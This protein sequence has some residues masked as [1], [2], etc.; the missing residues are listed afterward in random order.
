MLRPDLPA[1]E[2]FVAAFER[3]TGIRVDAAPYC[4]GASAAM[5][6]ELAALVRGGRKR[7]TAAILADYANAGEPLPEVGQHAAVHD[8]A[9]R[10]VCIVRTEEVTVGPLESVLDPA[11]AWDEG[12]GDRT[13]ENWLAGHT[14]YW[15]RTHAE[16][17][18]AVP[19]VLQRFRVVWPQVDRTLW[20]AERNGVRV[21]RAWAPDRQWLAETMR[22][23]WDGCVVSR[24]ALQDPARLPAL[25]AVDHDSARLG[26][27]TFR[28]RPGG[29]AEVVTVDALESGQGVGRLLLEAVTAVARCER[30][31]RLWL[32]TTNDN[33]V[34]LRAYQRAGWDLV[35]VHRDAVRYAR[36]LKPSIPSH[37]LDGIPITHELELHFPAGPPGPRP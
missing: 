32:I 15:R 16:L 13:V 10:P 37:G 18:A 2:D 12:E 11:F 4:Y 5:A 30:W 19:M 26:V 24:G 25:I 33:T 29:D 22:D 14:A 7:A 31:R 17:S 36:E 20:L 28:P 1:I 6:D 35:A 34:A 9:G 27:L 8:G 23:R 21:R 3:A